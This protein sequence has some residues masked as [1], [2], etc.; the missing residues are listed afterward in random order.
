MIPMHAKCIRNGV[1]TT[2]TNVHNLVKGDI[3]Y[4]EIGD[5]IPADMRIIESK[6]FKVTT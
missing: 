4:V 1:L 3:V 5:V 2:D 6:G